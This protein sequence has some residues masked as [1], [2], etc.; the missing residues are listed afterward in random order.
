MDLKKMAV[1][2]EWCLGELWNQGGSGT[3]QAEF[4]SPE[5]NV[6]VLTLVPM[7]GTLFRNGVFVDVSKMR[8]LK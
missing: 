2:K 1:T 5:R 6:K 3:S 7:T 4:C 8:L